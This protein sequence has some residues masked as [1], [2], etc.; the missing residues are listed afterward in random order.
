MENSVR[1]NTYNTAFG[2]MDKPNE[3]LTSGCF[4]CGNAFF[5]YNPHGWSEDN[6]PKIKLSNSPTKFDMMVNTRIDTYDEQ[7]KFN[8]QW[9][10]T[11]PLRRLFNGM[12][13]KGS[14][15]IVSSIT[16]EEYPIPTYRHCM[17]LKN[18]E[19]QRGNTVSLVQ[20]T[21]LIM[22]INVFVKAEPVSLEYYRNI[23]SLNIVSYV[24]MYVVSSGNEVESNYNGN[25]YKY[26]CFSIGD[27]R[28]KNM[29]G[30]RGFQGLAFRRS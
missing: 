26:Q 6:H 22:P 10:M 23:G 12:W 7:I 11:N 14:S 3:Y 19:T 9:G 20:N 27:R 13:D 17:W 29:D 18:K 16:H 4:I 24:S 25:T 8:T 30:L 15:Y 2:R 21:S 1:R 5:S 28:P